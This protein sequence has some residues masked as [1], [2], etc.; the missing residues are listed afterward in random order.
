MTNQTAT[1]LPRGERFGAGGTQYRVRPDLSTQMGGGFFED[2]KMR[3]FSN[4][5]NV[6]D[7]AASIQKEIRA[8][9]IQFGRGVMSA[10]FAIATTQELPH[11]VKREI[12]RRVALW[13]RN[14]GYSTAEM[15]SFLER[16]LFTWALP[17]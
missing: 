5:A 9:E 10:E 11:A 12:I 15:N 4:S 16:I 7:A 17:R 13:L 14:E 3:D 2:A 8:A 1:Q 6:I